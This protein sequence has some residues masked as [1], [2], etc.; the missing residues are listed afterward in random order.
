MKRFKNEFLLL[1]TVCKIERH[2]FERV[3][4]RFLNLKVGS[5]SQESLKEDFWPLVT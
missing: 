1:E 2:A 4:F 5:S 3:T